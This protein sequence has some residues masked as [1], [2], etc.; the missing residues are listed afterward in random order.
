MGETSICCALVL[1]EQLGKA[2]SPSFIPCFIFHY[3]NTQ[4]HCL[5]HASCS[6][7]AGTPSSPH[8]DDLHQKHSKASN[9]FFAR[10]PA[11]DQLLHP[12]Q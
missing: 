9:A 7:V 10:Y 3:H 2:S 4:V 6:S 1:Q 12:R 11:G 8:A 5:V